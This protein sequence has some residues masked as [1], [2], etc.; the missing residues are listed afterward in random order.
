ML[1]S[2]GWQAGCGQGPR[3]R[4]RLVAVL[5]VLAAI[6]L[7]C[8]VKLAQAF[9]PKKITDV[10]VRGANRTDEDTIRAIGGVDPGDT[11]EQDT[12]E[13]VRERLGNSGLFAKQDVFWE[14]HKS[15]ARVVINVE[16]KFPWAPVPTFSRSPGQIS[17]GAILVHGNLFGWGKQGVIGG[18]ISN[19][20]SGAVLGYRDPSIMGSWF[21]WQFETAFN[22][23]FIPEYSAESDLKLR[24]SKIQSY[25]FAGTFGIFWWRRVRTQFKLSLQQYDY[26]RCEE[27]QAGTCPAG[28]A[29][30]AADQRRGFGQFQLVFDFRAR[31]HAVVRG[32]ALSAFAQFANPSFLSDDTVDSVRTGVTYEH[33]IRFFKS[34]NLQFEGRVRLGTNLSFWDEI[35]VGGDTLRGYQFAQ[36]RGDTLFKATT[37]YHFPLFSVY[38]LDFRA[39]VFHDVAA[40]WWRKLPDPSEIG[41]RTFIPG[42]QRQ[43]FKA[44]RDINNGVGAGLR[45]YLRSVAV[46]LVGLDYGY[47]V[48]E[49]VWRLILI[50]GA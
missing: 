44:S 13:L 45:F 37:E 40:V 48:E 34:H 36:F 9:E 31:E 5:G 49:D 11:L 17:V 32:N 30:V 46:P 16:E 20:N 18:R 33:G 50:V 2:I 22:Q 4:R 14:P 35:N 19:V 47:A 39:L 23:R 21:Y 43:G 25:G 7:T 42:E 28:G 6:W 10:V 8:G 15:G 12:L 24:Q 1:N 27:F 29:K 38:S 41:G 26:Q 3:R